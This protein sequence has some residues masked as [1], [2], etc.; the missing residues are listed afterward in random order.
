MPR[1]GAGSGGRGG[2]RKVQRRVPFSTSSDG[3]GPSTMRSLFLG[4]LLE[5]LQHRSPVV[6]GHLVGLVPRRVVV[7]GEGQGGLATVLRQF[8]R[9]GV[10]VLG[11]VLTAA[12]RAPVRVLQEPFRLELKNGAFVDV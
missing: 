5:A 8:I 2:R 3:E 12:H 1:G 9:D 4:R 7:L 6:L 10:V 11:L